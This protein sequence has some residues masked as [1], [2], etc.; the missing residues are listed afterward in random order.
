[1]RHC[2]STRARE[3]RVGV[4][5]RNHQCPY[6]MRWH[7]LSN[8]LDGMRQCSLYDKS[9]SISLESLGTRACFP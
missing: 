4:A 8:P 9:D 3:T 6:R 2:V 5:H 1:M 7:S